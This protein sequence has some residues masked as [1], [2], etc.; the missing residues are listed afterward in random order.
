MDFRAGVRTCLFMPLLGMLRAPPR[1]S[2]GP[3]P[4]LWRGVLFEVKEGVRG[5]VILPQG[6]RHGTLCGHPPIYLNYLVSAS[7]APPIRMLHRTSTSTHLPPS[8]VSNLCQ[9]ADSL[10]S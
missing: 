6:V 1:Q 9:P 4:L 10:Y 7:P 8:P 3:P 2:Q 5:P